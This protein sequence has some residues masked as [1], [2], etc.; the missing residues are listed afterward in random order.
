MAGEPGDDALRAALGPRLR[1]EL[2]AME[3]W[4]PDDPDA[5][6]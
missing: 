3:S 2:D 4:T 5:G 1:A 6:A